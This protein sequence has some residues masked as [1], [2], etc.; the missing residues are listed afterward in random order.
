MLTDGVLLSSQLAARLRQRGAVSHT[1]IAATHRG[2]GSLSLCML[3]LFRRTGMEGH[4]A[5]G[6]K[7][8]P[9]WSQRR[10]KVGCTIVRLKFFSAAMPAPCKCEFTRTCVGSRRLLSLTQL[11]SRATPS[12]PLATWREPFDQVASDQQPSTAAAASWLT[13]GA[14]KVRS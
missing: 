9:Q 7:A 1:S 13:H 5:P 8:E 3:S 10:A 12:L 14:D 4:M 6:A 11:A 2:A